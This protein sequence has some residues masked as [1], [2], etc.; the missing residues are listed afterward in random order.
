MILY[1][2]TN[3][4]INIGGLIMRFKEISICGKTGLNIYISRKEKEDTSIQTQIKDYKKSYKD[5][6]VFIS[7]VE[8][9]EDNLKKI[10]SLYS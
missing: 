1:L 6:A 7:G 9:M 2:T 4:M 10:A 3:E 8:S 5:I